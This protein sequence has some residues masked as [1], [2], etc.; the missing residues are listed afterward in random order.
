MFDRARRVQAVPASGAS[1]TVRAGCGADRQKWVYI[2][3]RYRSESSFGFH[4]R[5]TCVNSDTPSGCG[6]KTLGPP[7]F[8]LNSPLA[9]R[10]TSRTTSASSRSRDCR[11]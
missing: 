10:A 7:I 9:E 3:R 2:P 4:G 5:F 6:G 11:G 1:K 8:G